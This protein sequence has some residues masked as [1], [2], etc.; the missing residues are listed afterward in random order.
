M[1]GAGSRDVSA[2]ALRCRFRAH[3]PVFAH[4]THL[5]VLSLSGWSSGISWSSPGS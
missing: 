3:V 4:P 5:G 2:T 1:P